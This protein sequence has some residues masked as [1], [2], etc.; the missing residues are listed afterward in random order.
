MV[1]GHKS[2]HHLH[3]DSC[4]IEALSVLKEDDGSLPEI[5]IGLATNSA[6]QIYTFLKNHASGFPHRPA[7]YWSE[8]LAKDVEIKWSDTASELL[9]RSDSRTFHVVFGE[10]ISPTGKAVPALGAFMS[11]NELILDFRMGDEWN[12]AAVEGLFEMISALLNIAGARAFEH[13]AN[14]F[15]HE[16]GILVG[17]WHAWRNAQREKAVQPAGLSRG[18]AAGGPANSLSVKTMQDNLFNLLEAVADEASLLSFAR[19]LAR[20]RTSVDG[21]SS[22]PDG[23][24]TEWAHQTISEF[25]GAAVAWAEDSDFGSRPGPKPSNPWQLIARFLWA[26]RTYE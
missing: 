20:D 14:Q 21:L 2:N 23:F 12:E 1:V 7:T 25:L 10:V 13:H 16:G 15:D 22:S 17:A 24:Q 9:Q 19:A 6:D 18:T 3:Q 26:G 5:R 4:L 8:A 11:T